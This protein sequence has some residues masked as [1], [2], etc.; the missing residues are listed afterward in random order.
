MGHRKIQI[1]CYADDAMLI[2]ENEDDLQRLLHRFVN[3]ASTFNMITSTEKTQSMVI[4]K[5]PI[6]CKLEVNNKIIQ[7]VMKFNYLGAIVSSNRNL[8]EEVRAQANRANRIAGYLREVIWRN[9]NMSLRSKVRIYKTCIRPILTYAVETRADIT[10]T[11]RILRTTEMRTLRA[12]RGV[13]LG[14]RMRSEQIR[15][16]CKIQDI[17]RWTRTRR[18]R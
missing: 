16:E 3:T 13:N 11:K 14:D 5:E 17:V 9:R 15:R 2:V 6:R 8:V 10:R 1:L 4:S 7:Q 12:I 18:R